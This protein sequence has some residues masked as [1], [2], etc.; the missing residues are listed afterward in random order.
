MSC[1]HY[2]H[3]I[4]IRLYE[5]DIQ[6]IDLFFHIMKAQYTQDDLE[7]L[8]NWLAQLAQQPYIKLGYAPF[9]QGTNGTGKN[10][11]LKNLPHYFLRVLP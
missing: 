11:L 6:G 4:P 1:H 9:L 8:L 7:A 2:N 3:L 5:N 10:I